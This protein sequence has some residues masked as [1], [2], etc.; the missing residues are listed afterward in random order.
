M[1]IAEFQALL[2]KVTD[3]IV[4]KEV[5]PALGEQLNKE[6]PAESAVFKDIAA[7]CKTGISEGW[8]CEN[9]HGGI[10]YGRPIKPTDDLA[11]CSV[12]V[13]LMNKLKGPHHKHPNGEIDMCIPIEGD[14]KF[15]GKGA[16]W[17]VYGAN[18]SHS[19]TV[20]DGEA[21][22]LYLLPGGAIEF[23]R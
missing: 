18:T 4:G 7:A 1:E 6:F 12:D 17:V 5:G 23:T 19:P 8:L 22:V 14:A 13:V 16:G 9:E 2:K 15:D 3:T 20:T 11:G 10:K 21:I